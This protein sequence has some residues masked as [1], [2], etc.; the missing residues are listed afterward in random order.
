[1]SAT[2]IMLQSKMSELTGEGSFGLP[3]EAEVELRTPVLSA[4][5]RLDESLGVYLSACTVYAQCPSADNR[6]ILAAAT[7]SHIGAA[8]NFLQVQAEDDIDLE[9]YLQVAAQFLVTQDGLRVDGINSILGDEILEKMPEDK[10]IG[11]RSEAPLDE[12]T[13]KLLVA[14][15]IADEHE[16]YVEGD[17]ERFLELIGNSPAARRL[18][19]QSKFRAQ[20]TE[21]GKLTLSAIIG[22]AVGGAIVAAWLKSRRS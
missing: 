19:E 15:G 14:Q 21:L 1:M 7:A 16:E 18:A 6:G 20:A 11:I 3:P 9:G 10:E 13:L 5:E 12:A 2:T 17:T 8:G 4:M 22:G